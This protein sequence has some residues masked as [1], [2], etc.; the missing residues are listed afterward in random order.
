MPFSRAYAF[1]VISFPAIPV[2][3]VLWFPHYS[4]KVNV[5]ALRTNIVFFS[6]LFT[7][8]FFFACGAGA[9]WNLALGNVH[10][11]QRLTV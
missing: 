9:F 8:I 3:L 6:T 7:L 5:C 10:A 1:H 2:L 11:G 4:S